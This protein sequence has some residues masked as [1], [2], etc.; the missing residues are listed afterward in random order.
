M[1]II[2]PLLGAGVG[3][4][5]AL[6]GQS[7]QRQATNLGYMNLYET[8]RA[9]RR[10]EAEQRRVNDLI[11]ALQ[12]ATRSDAL[13]NKISYDKALNEFS[14]ELTPMTQTTLDS[15]ANELLRQ[16]REDAPRNRAAAERKD[17]RSRMAD[18]QFEDVFRQYQYRPRQSE[19]AAISDATN[20]LLSARQ[21]GLKQAQG[22]IAKTLLRQGNTSALPE[23]ASAIS[24]Q[25]SDTLADALMQGRQLGGQ[26]FRE[27]EAANTNQFLTELNQLRGIAGD[28]TTS[29]VGR[30]NAAEDLT[31][32]SD[33]ALQQ[34]VA[35]LSS[36]GNALTSIIGQGADRTSSASAR[37]A[38]QLANSAPNL[39]GIASALSGLSF[40]GIT[41]QDPSQSRYI[42]PWEGL[43]EWDVV[44][45]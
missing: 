2:G 22:D 45:W 38:Q 5:Q 33:Q 39:S 25:Y 43:R 3:L 8:R 41:Q 35:A 16:L 26:R 27:S 4:A 36:G 11:E 9:N 42:D 15:Q 13:G 29:P 28:T 6:M 10:Q 44:G 12:T 23:A 32:R 31:N 24:R 30:S 21:T 20:E 17:R 19:Q 37:L 14:T 40:E 1:A 34:L 7:A 18:E